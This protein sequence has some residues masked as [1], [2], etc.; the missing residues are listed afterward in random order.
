MQKAYF[1]PRSPHGER[2]AESGVYC[3]KGISIHAPRTGS[4][5]RIAAGKWLLPLNFNPR[6]PHGERHQIK[7]GNP[8]RMEI[9]I[10]AP[11]TG[12][13]TAGSSSATSKDDFNPRS[14][15]GERHRVPVRPSR[16]GDF[17]PRSPHGERRERCGNYQGQQNFNP[18]SPHGE[19]LNQTILTASS[20]AF[21]STLPA[22]GATC[23]KAVNVTRQG[24]SIHAPRTGSDEND[25]LR[26]RTLY[27]FN[28]RSPHGERLFFVNMLLSYNAISIHAPR[29]G[30]DHFMGGRVLPWMY[31]NPRSPHGERPTVTL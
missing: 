18:R 22:R 15:H 8:G 28:P 10:H 29:T 20:R 25:V 14:P 2:P 24:I 7:P 30:S 26:F 1:N 9:S 3:R 16:P 31:F 11:R 13:D 21:Q 5:A 19:R 17:N 27:N 6:S 12:S 4:D 23:V